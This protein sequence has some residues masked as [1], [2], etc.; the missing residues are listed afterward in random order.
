MQVFASNRPSAWTDDCRLINSGKPVRPVNGGTL[1]PSSRSPILPEIAFHI[2]LRR[3][4]VCGAQKL[5]R[6]E[7]RT[8]SSGTGPHSFNSDEWGFNYP[9]QKGFYPRKPSTCATFSN[10]VPTSVIGLPNGPR[11]KRRFVK[12]LKPDAKVAAVARKT[13][14][15][16]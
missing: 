15:C 12:K 4:D 11:V 5:V 8:P 14:P 2:P 3:P 6:H 13:S 16:W 10:E 1:N 9:E 7:L